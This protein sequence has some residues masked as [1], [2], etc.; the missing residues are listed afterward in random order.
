M[1]LTI[2]KSKLFVFSVIFLIYHIALVK[3]PYI[4]NYNSIRYLFSIIL[5][6]PLLLNMKKLL[7]LV[8][9]K[10]VL[11]MLIYFAFVIL[12]ALINIK[13][14]PSLLRTST[15]YCLI[16]LEI[17][18]V[19]L[20]ACKKESFNY[21]IKTLF[22]FSIIYL[23]INDIL[24]IF[25]PNMFM[26]SGEYY[27]VGNKFSVSYLHLQ[28]ILLYLTERST[29]DNNKK[30]LLINFPTL[31]LFVVTVFI[32]Q[33]I[34]C[35][36]GTIGLILILL[37]FCLSKRILY[38][39]KFI[40]IM[41]ILST[42]FAFSYDMLLSN[43]TIQK[44]IVNILDRTL[45][46]TGRTEI[47]QNIPNILSGHYLFGY[48]YGQSYNVWMNAI[49]MPN[50]QN[51]II[52]LIVETGLSTTI[53]LFFIICNIFKLLNNVKCDNYKQ[54][55]MPV[56]IMIYIYLILSAFEITIGLP[57]ICFLAIIY[58]Y[59]KQNNNQLIKEKT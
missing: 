6:L 11:L 30:T 48:G 16:F 54:N 15:F 10:I 33:K 53:I 1:N 12:S 2:K 13:Y 4:D 31:A 51:G 20:L 34:D 39:S 3:F 41:A 8:N 25:S 27:L 24:I 57:F 26:E 44:F 18:L 38:N 46:L 59:I 22:F 58:S 37:L 35:M 50:S 28:T 56:V 36:T 55:I 5:L 42:L 40:V 32:T 45:T 43:H 21:C 23:I 9:K 52:D 19:F 7:N 47:Y 14:T 17:F 49:H 29:K